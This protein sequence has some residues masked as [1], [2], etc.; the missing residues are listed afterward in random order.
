MCVCV[1]YI[2]EVPDGEDW[3]WERC[4]WLLLSPAGKLA[5]ESQEKD[6]EWKPTATVT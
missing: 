5:N 6:L 3:M 2:I 1:L 4:W